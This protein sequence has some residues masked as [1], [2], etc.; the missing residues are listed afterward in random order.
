MTQSLF[1]SLLE[2]AI[3]RRR[4]YRVYTNAPAQTVPAA[5]ARVE[6]FDAAHPPSREI[7]QM[8]R[9]EAG[10]L[11]TTMMMHRLRRRGCVLLIMREG[12][13][14]IAFGWLQSLL[15]LQREFWW[16]PQSGTCLGPYW[17]HPDHR[18][19]GLY[20]VLLG[21]SLR[22]AGARKRA[23]LFIWAQAHNESSIRGIEKAGFK[24]LGAYRIHT[25]LG[26]LIRKRLPIA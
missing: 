6:V 4:A 12:G 19:K 22:E 24:F 11:G 16:L 26:G 17:T 25:Y 21:Q 2:R 10:A 15:V 9:A 13:T 3:V 23:E 20:G 7:V 5:D 18:G 1:R 14:L 8:Y